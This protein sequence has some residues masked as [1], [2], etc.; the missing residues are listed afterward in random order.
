MSST[1]N[2]NYTKKMEQIAEDPR[3]VEA[4]LKAET[5]AGAKDLTVL[6]SQVLV[7]T[8]VQPAR[9]KGGII[10]TSKSRDE[11]RFQ[12]KLGMVIAVGPG[13]FKD[14]GIAKFHGLS[15]KVGDWVFARASDGLELFINAVPCRVFEDVAIKMIVKTPELYW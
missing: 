2:S 15:V 9:T 14:D 12:G 8:Y 13:A 10:L 6:H 11:D 4:A 1:T 3:G 7:A 5:A